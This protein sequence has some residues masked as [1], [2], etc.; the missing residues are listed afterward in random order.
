M[1]ETVKGASFNN[2]LYFEVLNEFHPDIKLTVN[3]KAFQDT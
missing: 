3:P 2:I 1:T